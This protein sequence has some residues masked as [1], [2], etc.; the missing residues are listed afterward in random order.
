MKLSLIAILSFVSIGIIKAQTTPK[1]SLLW[2]V[3]GNGLQKPSYLFGTFHIMCKENFEISPSLKNAF[4]Q[5]DQ[6]FEEMKMDDPSIQLKMMTMMVSS[7]SLKELLGEE[8]YEKTA[9]EFQKITG[10][11]LLLFN[12]M[13][14][15]AA[16]SLLTQKSITCSETVMPEMEF[17]KLAKEANKEVLGLETVEDE[18]KAIDKISIDSQITSLKRMVHNFDSTKTMMQLM[19]NEYKKRD[20]EALEKMMRENGASGDFETALLTERN[21][22]WIFVIEKAMQTKPSFF[23]FGAGHLGGQ[24]GILNLLKQKGYILKPIAY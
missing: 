17:V 14:P 3:S 10:M 8:A 6:L 11:P 20:P 23:A 7:T 24:T 1:T 12:K 2:E 19:E 18:I 21:K 4:N 15:F 22:A 9:T 13:K 16:I 5:T